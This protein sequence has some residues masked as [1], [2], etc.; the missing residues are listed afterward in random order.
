MM[1]VLVSLLLCEGGGD[2]GVV[3]SFNDIAPYAYQRNKFVVFYAL[4][5]SLSVPLFTS[6]TVIA[7]S[8]SVQSKH[9][10]WNR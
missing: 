5:I 3:L 10:N 9:F 8:V 2:G 1:F 7:K 4:I 6:N